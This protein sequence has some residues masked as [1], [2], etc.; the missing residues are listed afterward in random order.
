MSWM[1][2]SAVAAADRRNAALSAWDHSFESPD[3]YGRRG[4]DR[5]LVPPT[6][7]M[8]AEF[9]AAQADE[10]ARRA[11]ERAKWAAEDAAFDALPGLIEAGVTEVRVF[12]G[13]EDGWDWVSASV[14]EHREAARVT[15]GKPSDD[16]HAPVS[17]V[18]KIAKSGF[19]WL[20]R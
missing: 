5:E 16:W 17:R 2:A 14:W 8:I 13:G 3:G 6:A 4:E 15:T 20:V 12:G 19:A 1:N 7:E 10:A 9:E 18:A 11:E